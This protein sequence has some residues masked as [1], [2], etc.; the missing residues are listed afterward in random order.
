MIRKIISGGQTG[1]DIGGL[2]VAK[3]LGLETGGHIPKGFLTQKGRKYEYGPIFG[4][5]ET[6]SETYPER[7]ELNV[8]NSDGTVRFAEFWESP[9]ERCTKKYI[10]KHNK[11]HW[12]VKD[13]SDI[14]S[15]LTWIKENNIQ[16]LNVAGNSERTSPGIQSLVQSFLL[17]ALC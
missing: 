11:P 5:V 17:E 3:V 6:E 15:F 14:S 9:G 2:Y 4:L 7:T 12:D 16:V 10:D 8:L 13:L 1:A